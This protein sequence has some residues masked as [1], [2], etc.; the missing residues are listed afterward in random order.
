MDARHR[1]AHQTR[2]GVRPDP[3]IVPSDLEQAHSFH[4]V[5]MNEESGRRR[6]RRGVGMTLLDVATDELYVGGMRNS[7]A[8]LYI[9]QLGVTLAPTL[10]SDVP[11]EWFAAEGLEVL[12][13]GFKQE[14]D[15]G[16][17]PLHPA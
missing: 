1:R 9:V 6:H 11:G 4:E 13:E 15:W 14:N 3:V 8:N 2:Q 17:P 5:R 16:L 7:R 12:E 10:P